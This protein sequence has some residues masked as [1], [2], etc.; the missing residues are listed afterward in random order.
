MAQEQSISH[1]QNIY[2]S[3]FEAKGGHPLE[4]AHSFEVEGTI[5]EVFQV[6]SNTSRVN[7]RLKV[8]ERFE[9][10]V[11]G[12]LMV[13]TK[14]LGMDVTW[15]ELPWK[16]SYG[17]YI[18]ADR[19]FS[20]GHLHWEHAVFAFESLSSKRQRVTF[21]YRSQARKLWVYLL[22]KFALSPFMKQ[23]EKTVQEL[24]AEDQKGIK[25]DLQLEN[26][27]HINNQLFRKIKKQ[28]IEL[29]ISESI[30][31]KLAQSIL[32]KE[33][34]EIY[35]LHIPELSFEWMESREDLVTA[36]LKAAKAGILE[37]CWE[38]KCPHCRGT[39][40]SSNKLQN[41]V[42]DINC[43]PCNVMVKLSSF[44]SI[45]VC[46]KVSPSIRKVRNISFCAGEP[47]K[48][49]HIL[50]NDMIRP[51]N[52]VQF[53][54]FILAGAYRVRI[55]G[56]QEALLIEANS[57]NNSKKELTWEGSF[58][59]EIEYIS[60]NGH[61][62]Y[63]NKS[64]KE[65]ELTIEYMKEDDSIL[66]PV[67]VFANP[68]FFKFYQDE[69]LGSGIQIK[70]PK[71]VILFTDVVNSTVFY[72]E[73]GDEEAFNQIKLHFD[74]VQDVVSE[75]QGMIVKTI[76]DAVM[77]SFNHVDDLIAAVAKMDRLISEKEDITI[78]LRYS[79]HQGDMIAVNYNTGIDFFGNNV[80]VA[81]KL[82]AIANLQELAFSKDIFYQS[83]LYDKIPVDIRTYLGDRDGYVIKLADIPK[84]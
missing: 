51:G 50:F 1:F 40:E 80:N 69:E 14:F 7:H 49:S 72:Q 45:D 23:V 61:I 67:E 27:A 2:P 71:R 68:I 75:F 13:D 33:D 84:N 26:T 82:Q 66:S 58:H 79:A 9:K 76:G 47:H 4:I 39:R 74:I 34:H 32:Y 21:Y 35:R 46:F 53:N 44:N 57:D 70:L 10:E 36:F 60:M 37:V 77:A 3:P 64:E 38:V 22:M 73:Q 16:W 25:Q 78:G 83:Q 5:A 18:I 19:L 11:Q 55:K 54:H 41:L 28:L 65:Q 29:N 56:Q 42:G 62:T 63:Q 15:Q 24:V 30:A 17:N 43:P 48:K 31:E 52:E 6:V 12:R 20:K 59:P 81:A 8:A